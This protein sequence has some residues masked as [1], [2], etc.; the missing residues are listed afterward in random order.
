MYRTLLKYLTLLQR[1]C[2]CIQPFPPPHSAKRSCIFLSYRSWFPTADAM[3]CEGGLLESWESEMEHG[4]VRIMQMPAGLWGVCF[5]KERA[6][7]QFH[8]FHCSSSTSYWLLLES[9]IVIRLRFGTFKVYDWKT[10]MAQL[11]QAVVSSFFDKQKRNLSLLWA[12]GII[13]QLVHGSKSAQMDF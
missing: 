7:T 9:T 13:H 6:G 8:T 5:C 4:C 1:V 12:P 2:V 11:L 3:H 10:S